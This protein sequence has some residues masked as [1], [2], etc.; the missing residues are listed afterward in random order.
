MVTGVSYHRKSFQSEID[1]NFCERPSLSGQDN[2]PVR[3][4]IRTIFNPNPD[5]ELVTIETLLSNPYFQVL[6]SSHPPSLSLAHFFT[7]LPLLTS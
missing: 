6:T 4:I 5:E 7:S 2:G 3:E 1:D